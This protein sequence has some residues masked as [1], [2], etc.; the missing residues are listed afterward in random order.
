M[1]NVYRAMKRAEQE[2]GAYPESAAAMAPA[3][4]EI[5]ARGEDVPAAIDTSVRAVPPLILGAPGGPNGQQ[6][7]A[8][9]HYPMLAAHH[10]RGGTVA[11]QFRHIRTSLL[12]QYPDGR[13]VLMVT[14][15]DAGEGKTVSTGNMGIILA[16][17]QDRT[18]LIMDCDL[19]RA[20]LTSLYRSKQVVGVTDMLRGKATLAQCIQRTVYPNLYMISA[21]TGERGEI[22]ELLARPELEDI[23][24]Q[25][26]TQFDHVL[27]DAP[28]VN[29]V[30][31]AGVLGHAV[32]EAMMVVRMNKTNRES[33]ERAVRLLKAA[34]VKIAGMVLTHQKYFVPNYIYKYS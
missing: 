9:G 11:E 21:G 27:M 30:A 1:S 28:P 34:N 3:A 22:A 7:L 19:R 24:E 2:Q 23:I 14:S 15:A 20:T 26:R 17:R 31:D 6:L 12:A 32:G 25:V 13:F 8:D 5:D 33:V 29:S 18:T 16:E 4:I 10:D